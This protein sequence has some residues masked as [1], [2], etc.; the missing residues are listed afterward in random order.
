MRFPL[1]MA[2]IAACTLAGC[3]YRS[4]PEDRLRL[5]DSPAEVSRCR[6]LGRVGEPVRT[7]G[8]MP[9]FFDAQIFAGPS[10]AFFGGY[11]GQNTSDNLSPRI[12]AMKSAA[13]ALGATDLLLTRRFLRDWSYIQGTAYLCRH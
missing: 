5:I 10:E 8:K 11:G 13:I 1:G 4:V 6:S 2:M 9:A 12:D 7:D 3:Q